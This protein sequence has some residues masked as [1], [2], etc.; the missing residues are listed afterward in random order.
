MV[1]N[2]EKA[3]A[4]TLFTTS[5]DRRLRYGT[6]LGFE[7]H[8]PLIDARRGYDQRVRQFALHQTLVDRL[9]LKKEL[10]LLLLQQLFEYPDDVVVGFGRALNETHFPIDVYY[11][12]GQ[13]FLNHSLV[14]QI[15]NGFMPT[16]IRIV[17]VIQFW[18]CR[19]ILRAV[20]S[21]L[22]DYMTTVRQILAQFG[23]KS[24]E[25]YFQY[26]PQSTRT[27]NYVSPL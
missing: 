25:I 24:L 14:L 6:T 19:A 15:C 8:F 1:N 22:Y 20:V 2:I 23:W 16:E 11:R 17:I 9:L 4:M 13:L 5:C 27:F 26:C 21:T 10:R 18:G 3:I 12:F 7:R